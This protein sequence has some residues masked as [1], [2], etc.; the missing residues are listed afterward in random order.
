MD[1]MPRLEIASCRNNR[2]TNR[3]ASDAAAF[4]INFGTTFRMNSPVSAVAFVQS[5]MRSGDNGICVLIGDITRDETQ[6]CL[7]N[8]GFHR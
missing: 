8:F 2:I 6:D 4:L 7:S 1:H 3:T 5:P